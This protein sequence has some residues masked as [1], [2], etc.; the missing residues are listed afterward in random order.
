MSTLIDK[1][2]GK[3]I[4]CMIVFFIIS[5]LCVCVCVYT[6]FTGKGTVKGGGGNKR[7]LFYDPE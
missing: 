7:L 4:T 6:Y 3:G 5:P 2:T 1:N